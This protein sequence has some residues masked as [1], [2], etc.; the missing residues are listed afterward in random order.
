VSAER[1]LVLV[2]PDGVQRALIGEIIGR[3]ERR[4]LHLVGA[5]FTRITPELAS[6]HY[7][8]HQ[9]KPFYDGLVTFITS[10]PVMAMVWEG[11]GAVAVVRA[12]MGTTDPANSLPGTI[13]GDLALSM[14]MNVVHGSDSPERGRQEI[15]LFFTPAELVEW[16][17]ITKPWTGQK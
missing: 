15:D 10:G 7:A 9:G 1:T 3:L 6:R 5:K 11:P 8:E 12:M 2:K 17:S 13:R 4:E 14:K 16:E